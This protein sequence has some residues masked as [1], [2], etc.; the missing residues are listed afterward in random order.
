MRPSQA[1]KLLLIASLRSDP[2]ASSRIEVIGIVK[3]FRLRCVVDDAIGHYV[4]DD[5]FVSRHERGDD[6]IDAL[7]PEPNVVVNLTVG[8]G[9]VGADCV[10]V[11]VVAH[12]CQ[13][14]VIGRKPNLLT[15]V[16]RSVDNFLFL[17]ITLIP[18]MCM[19]MC[20]CIGVLYIS[21]IYL[22]YIYQQFGGRSLAHGDRL[23]YVYVLLQ[24][25]YVRIVTMW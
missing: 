4:N 12:E 10:G 3:P 14:I 2:R 25:E 1:R 11:A 16:S 19:C 5:D 18:A 20:M 15:K 17:W 22:A 7:L 24:F 6:I 21:F 13:S 23:F 8:H 9:D